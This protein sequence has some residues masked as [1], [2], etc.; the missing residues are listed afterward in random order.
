MNHNAT[1]ENF[2]FSELIF[3]IAMLLLLAVLWLPA[4]GRIHEASHT[5]ACSGH[6][7]R[8][9]VAAAQYAADNH[10]TLPAGTTPYP[11]RRY[12]WVLAFGKYLSKTPDN[13]RSITIGFNRYSEMPIFCPA[14][15][16]DSGF[17]Y[18]A[19]YCHTPDSNAK[20]PF[21]YYENGK[22]EKSCFARYSRLRPEIMMIGDATS[23]VAYNPRQYGCGPSRDLSGN[24]IPDSSGAKYNNYAPDRHPEGMNFVRCDGTVRSA[25]FEEWE[26]NLNNSGWLYN[27]NY[28][29]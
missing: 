12:R 8:I 7:K 14:A 26:Q 29:L 20:L 1:S 15:P 10:D 13:E 21:H 25:S 24:D 19:N 3:I 27:E 16:P 9:G 6:L 23:M 2:T 28:D 22:P 5:V 4:M 18:G 11:D 17:T